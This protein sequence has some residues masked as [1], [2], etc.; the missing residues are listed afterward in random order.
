MEYL[1]LVWFLKVK[2]AIFVGDTYFL[3]IFSAGNLEYLNLVQFLK[4]KYAFFCRKYNFFMDFQ[5]RKFGIPQFS[6]VFKGQIRYFLSKI[7]FL[8]ISNAGNLEY[9]NL[10]R[11]LKVKY[12]MF[13]ENTNFSYIV[14]GFFVVSCE[15]APPPGGHP[16]A[17]VDAFGRKS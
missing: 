14:N 5:C 6:T 3:C 15:N 7:H 8:C 2:Y 9:L 12:S 1:N 17:S 4:V 16:G 13:V 10:V 11:F